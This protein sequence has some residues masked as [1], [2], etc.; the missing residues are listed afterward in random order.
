M[1]LSVQLGW[2]KA[3]VKLVGMENDT[4]MSRWA[5]GYIYQHMGDAAL[6][7]RVDAGVYLSMV[8]ASVDPP[9]QS[10]HALR[11]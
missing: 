4:H 6:L 3:Y 7:V 11:N 9:S 1:G 5:L 2:E 8:R 10:K